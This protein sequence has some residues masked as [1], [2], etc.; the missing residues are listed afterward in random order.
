MALCG[1]I[2]IRTF[3][4][5]SREYMNTDFTYDTIKKVKTHEQEQEANIDKD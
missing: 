1:F 4:T 2:E 3:E 5:L